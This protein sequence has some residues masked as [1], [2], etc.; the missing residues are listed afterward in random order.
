MLSP[1]PPLPLRWPLLAF[2]FVFLSLDIA[3]LTYELLRRLIIFA[4]IG[5]S[6][7]S[8]TPDAVSPFSF[9]RFAIY[10]ELR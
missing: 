6:L 1:L 2:I 5:F 7:F 8:A 10:T 3:W 4:D 9:L